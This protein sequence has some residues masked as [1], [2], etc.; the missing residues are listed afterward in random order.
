MYNGVLQKSVR[1]MEEWKGEKMVEIFVF[2]EAS[3]I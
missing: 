2:N 3:Q 1:K